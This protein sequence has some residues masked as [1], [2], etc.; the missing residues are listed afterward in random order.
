[1]VVD[2][3]TG[4]IEHSLFHRLGEFL[5]AGDLLVMNDTRVIRGRLRARRMGTGG[6]AEFLL[7]RRVSEG[8]WQGV[9]RPGRRMRA[10]ERFEVERAGVE[11]EVQVQG[12]GEDGTLTLLLSSETGMEEWGETPLPPYIREPLGDPE[13]YQ[14][15]YARDPGSAA[16]PTAG[17]HF[18]DELLDRLELQGVDRTYLTLHVGLDTFRPV[19]EEDPRRHQ[20][21]KEFCRLDSA[22]AEK[23]NTCRRRGGR[24][25]AVGTTSVRTLEQTGIWLQ[26]EV[27]EGEGAPVSGWA[28]L[29]ILAGYDFRMVDVD[30]NELSSA[31]IHDADDDGCICRQGTTDGGL[32]GSD[33]GG[34]PLLQLWGCDANNVRRYGLKRGIRD[35]GKGPAM[36]T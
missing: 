33:K 3:A 17:L 35:W 12:R 26:E 10:G 2:R 1:M 8:V 32:R 36:F 18:T 14:T 20:I 7:L 27:Q 11:V 9:G 6:R 5:R 34:V 30:D 15:V 25:V 31:E 21:H 23:I 16:A 4:R 29:L 28:E 13:R 19:T 24:V 22:A